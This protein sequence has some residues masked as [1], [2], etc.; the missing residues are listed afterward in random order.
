MCNSLALDFPR[1]RLPVPTVRSRSREGGVAIFV[2][3]SLPQ[4]QRRSFFKRLGEGRRERGQARY[5]VV[6]DERAL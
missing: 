4:L 6:E 2:S 3:F 1:A 5:G